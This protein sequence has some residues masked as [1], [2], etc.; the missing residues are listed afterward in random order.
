MIENSYTGSSRRLE[1]WDWSSGHGKAQGI[2]CTDVVV[3]SWKWQDIQKNEYPM[4]TEHANFITEWLSIKLVYTF[5]KC[6]YFPN[7]FKVF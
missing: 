4:R 6:C 3:G 5:H 7:W 2:I 1:R